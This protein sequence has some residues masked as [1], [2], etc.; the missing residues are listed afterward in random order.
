MKHSQD[1]QLIS[2]IIP[3]FNKE[4][5]IDDC[6]DSVVCQTYNAIEILLIDDGSTDASGEKCDEW[7]LKDSRI[8]VIHTVNRG[9]S[10]ARNTGLELAKGQFI[11][12]VDAD[13]TVTPE[14]IETMYQGITADKLDMWT[15]YFDEK[16]WGWCDGN[17]SKYLLNQRK[18]AVWGY[19][20]RSD[21][22]KSTKFQEDINNNEDFVYLY[23]ISRIT[24][25]V[26][27]FYTSDNNVYKYNQS[28]SQS[29][30]KQV[31]ISRV[32]STLR[33]VQYVEKS[34]PSN[35][36]MEFELY[37]FNM[38]LYVLS[39]CPFGKTEDE[40]LIL[41]K[42]DMGRYLRRHF[43]QWL[44]SPTRSSVMGV[45]KAVCCA[46]FPSAYSTIV[47]VIKGAGNGK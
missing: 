27:G 19:I 47:S 18:T 28:D 5:F 21:I 37:A 31:S 34:T 11:V 43:V 33:A 46:F 42:R 45:A 3:V 22:V 16:L 10:A 6:I 23:E 29:L 15:S 7:S 26:S 8:R 25:R 20:F 38:Y 24:S 13:D 36:R 32:N 1:Y 44:K 40:D 12:F 14:A 30:C 17:F 9:V 2:V 4:R 35:L 41:S 39:N